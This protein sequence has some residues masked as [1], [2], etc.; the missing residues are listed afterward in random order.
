MKL[1][2]LC[3]KQQSYAYLI[4]YFFFK[5]SITTSGKNGEAS[6]PFFIISRTMVEATWVYLGWPVK[7]TVSMVLSKVPGNKQML[8]KPPCF[9][10]KRCLTSVQEDE[11][12]VNNKSYA[13]L[14]TGCL[15]A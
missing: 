2:I 14:S 7:K 6:P 9:L 11:C 4:R 1:T 3:S 12:I 5:L 13:E 8:I 10:L 15:R